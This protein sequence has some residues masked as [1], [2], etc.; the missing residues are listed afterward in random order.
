MGSEALSVFHMALLLDVESVQQEQFAHL[1]HN[2][3]L[4]LMSKNENRFP[5]CF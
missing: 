1:G 2:T 5:S 4:G 3:L